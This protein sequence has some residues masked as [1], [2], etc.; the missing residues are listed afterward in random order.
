MMKMRRPP[1]Q[2]GRGIRVCNP[3]DYYQADHSNIRYLYP[4]EAD[5]INTCFQGAEYGAK[6]KL[7]TECRSAADRI[8][9]LMEAAPQSAAEPGFATHL[10]TTKLTI[11]ILGTPTRTKLTSSTPVSLER[12]TELRIT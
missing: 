8:D 7:K 10:I 4:N 1:P 11:R 12:D 3:P 5:V 6:D 9:R 2:L